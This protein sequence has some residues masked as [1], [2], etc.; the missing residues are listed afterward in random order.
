MLLLLI[1]SNIWRHSRWSNAPGAPR[2]NGPKIY[3]ARPGHPFLYRIP[4]QGE[5]PMTFSARGLPKTLR[6]DAQT[7]II[8]GTT[9]ERG[10]YNVTLR[11]KNSHGRDHRSFK[12]VSGDTLALTPPMGW[13]HWYAHYDRI[14]DPMVREAADIMISSGM[15]DVGA[16]RCASARPVTQPE[17]SSRINISPT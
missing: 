12:I 3:G 17:T 14:T 10:E 13:N 5:R 4:T 7:G 2:I 15:A 16:T 9:P 1:T 8:T 11:A 6:L